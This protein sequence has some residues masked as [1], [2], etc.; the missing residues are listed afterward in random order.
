MCREVWNIT[1][2][3]ILATTLGA[4]HSL[5]GEGV[6]DALQSTALAELAADEVVDAILGLVHRLDA[7]DLGL[8]ESVC[9][10]SMSVLNT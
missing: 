7:G 1:Y 3:V 4:V 10:R 9:R 6:A 5:L 2:G 8:V